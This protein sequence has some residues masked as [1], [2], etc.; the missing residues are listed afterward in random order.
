MSG[1][2]IMH[3]GW[4]DSFKPEPF[5]EREA[6]LWSIEQAAILA[7]D[8]W[9]NGQ[10][11]PVERGEF[12]TSLRLMAEA[13]SWTVKRVRGFME[14]MGKAEKWAQRQAHQ[15]AQSPTIIS[16]LNYEKYQNVADQKGTAE[17]TPKGT[18]GAQQGH[19]KGTQ[20]NK[21][22]KGNKGK[23]EESTPYSLVDQTLDPANDQPS[24]LPAPD[25]VSDAFT[26]FD[27]I[28]QEF[29]P[30]ARTMELSPDRRKKL[31]ARL[32]EIG[33]A[34]GWAE[35]VA[36]IRGS[37]FLRGEESRNGFVK[38]DWLLEPANL[39]KVREGN[40]D[41]HGNRSA[42]PAAQPVRTGPVAAINIARDRLGLG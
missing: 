4:M 18:R 2:Y 39:R 27:A 15:G 30:N 24:F 17:G 31:A 37:P 34:A 32:R 25:E 21:G 28:R 9:F 13:F 12:A 10:R 41:H 16:V 8:Q 42:G 1:W 14:R 23:K 6:F 22:N 11:I 40:Y 7:H 38:L 3:R 20:Q 36:T 33:G 26:A 29:V 35:V 5:T 19:S